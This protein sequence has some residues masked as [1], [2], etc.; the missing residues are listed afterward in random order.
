MR[1]ARLR[2]IIIMLVFAIA[3]GVYASETLNGELCNISS[4]EVIEGN[5]YVLCGELRIAGQVDGNVI[6]VA[7]VANVTGGVDDSMYLIGGE[8][9]VNGDVGKDLHFAGLVLNVEPEATFENDNSG[10]LSLNLSHS[11]AEGAVVPGNI[12]NL[13]Y[14]LLVNGRVTGRVEF[15]GSSLE[16]NGSVDGDVIA[17]VG[18]AE[19]DDAT[20]QIE[21]LLIPFPFEVELRVP[22]LVLGENATID[23]QLEYTGPT[24]GDFERNQLALPPVWNRTG[25]PIFATPEQ[26]AETLQR[27][28]RAIVREFSTLAFVGAVFVLLV[29]RQ[30]QSPLRYLQA[31]PVS[32]LGVGM[33]SFILSFPIFLLVIL[34]SVLIIFVLSLLPLDPVVIFGGVVLGLANI[35]SAS[36]FYFTAIYIARV[37]VALAIGRVALRLLNR[38]RLSPDDSNWRLFTTLL[39]GVFA[40][41]VM[42]SIPT[43]GWVFNALTVFIGLGAILNLLQ[44]KLRAFVE[45]TPNN[46][47]PSPT[48]VSSMAQPRPLLPYLTEDAQR[49]APPMIEDEPPGGVGTDN[50]PEGFNWWGRASDDDESPSESSSD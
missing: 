29:P 27:Y 5:L 38:A 35:G 39:I 25:D 50:L 36:I 45:S 11:I 3:S 32:T 2:T 13:G 21:R 48:A 1:K 26:S 44:A 31:R 47:P 20:S 19:S 16:I 12:T 49:F 46:V 4:D 6:G 17:S 24:R 10:I 30:M 34:L 28:L 18:N 42:G 40:I 8:L 43:L 15:W 9:N 41:S 37:V 33:L 22:G 23:G 7:R 14:Q